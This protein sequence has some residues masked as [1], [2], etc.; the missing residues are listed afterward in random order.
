MKPL[1]LHVRLAWLLSAALA[2]LLFGGGFAAFCQTPAAGTTPAQ[3][4]NRVVLPDP[5]RPEAQPPLDVDRD[6]VPTLDIEVAP[7]AKP[8]NTASTPSAPG[9]NGGIEKGRNGAYVLH[10][11]VDEVLL[12]CTVIDSK[13]QTVTD[14]D[15]S[16]FR[17]WEDGVPQTVTAYIH[18]DEPVSMGIL[19]DNSGSMR[20][21]RGAVNT[22]ALDLLR[23]SN[24]Q[25]SAFI[26]NFSDRA[27]LDQGFTSDLVALNRGLSRFDSKGTTALYDAVAASADELSKHGPQ[28]KQVLLIITDGGDNASRLTL[29]AAI[30][31]VQNLAGPVVYSIGLLYDDD[32]EEASQARNALET[33]SEETGGIAYF[34]NSLQDVEAIAANVA[35]D[36][37][38][39]YTVAYNSTN[40]MSRGGFR[41][42]RVEAF[43][44]RHGKLIVRTKRGYYANPAPTQTAQ[45]QKP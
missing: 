39:Q 1:S 23:E 22:A 43:A 8:G 28:R 3:A 17:V 29:A 30:R 20:D 7:T 42:V 5:T 27:Y 41:T 40:P 13:G 33:L 34:P 36:I 31:R 9:Q 24:R 38:E 11:N 32:K 2:A 12:N 37:R 35:R 14:L 18:Q 4:G 25:D 19:V 44:P 16:D 21:K 6:P 45:E 15:K 26:V 10:T